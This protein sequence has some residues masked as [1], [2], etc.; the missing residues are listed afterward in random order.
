M[1][2]NEIISKNIRFFLIDRNLKVVELA[3]M[4]NMGKSTLYEIVNNTR[5]V[6]DHYVEGIAKALGVESSALTEDNRS[7]VS[8]I[9]LFEQRM[10]DH[11]YGLE[12]KKLASELMSLSE[13]HLSA[14][15]KFLV[16]RLHA[17]LAYFS[18]S[19]KEASVAYQQLAEISRYLTEAGLDFSGEYRH[20]SRRGLA[21][22]YFML[23]RYEKVKAIISEHL[24]DSLSPEQK[25][26]CHHLLGLVYKKQSDFVES[27]KQLT[28]AITEGTRIADPDIEYALSEIHQ[29]LGDL[30]REHNQLDKAESQLHHAVKIARRSHHGRA[31][32]YAQRSLALI[33]IARA[34]YSIAV[35]NLESLQKRIVQLGLNASE[36]YVNEFYIARYSN[37][38][39]RMKLSLEALSAYERPPR[40]MAAIY[41]R[42]GSFAKQLERWD[43]VCEFYEKALAL[44]DQ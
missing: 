8:L 42:A 12:T 10:R 2:R 9:A 13:T 17:D 43:D 29:T 38:Y 25:V 28:C 4:A 36:H 21:S 27:D 44:K 11:D 1:S 26:H 20:L 41:E 7:V 22:A 33:S 32:V 19:Y 5:G 37:E 30:Y 6:A 31:E 23:G 3:K 14:L 34:D 39:D 18:Y 40:E 15:Q 35:E 16:V 24:N